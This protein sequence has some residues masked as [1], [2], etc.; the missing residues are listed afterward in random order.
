LRERVKTGNDETRKIWLEWQPPKSASAWEP[1]STCRVLARL[2]PMAKAMNSAMG[3]SLDNF[4]S[5][6]TALSAFFFFA[7]CCWGPYTY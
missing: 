2:A 3:L 4:G 1:K 7:R 6:R 5:Y